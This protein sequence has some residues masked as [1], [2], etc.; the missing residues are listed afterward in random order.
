[1][2]EFKETLQTKDRHM[3]LPPPITTVPGAPITEIKK[4]VFLVYTKFKMKFINE[5]NQT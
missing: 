2:S 3:V 5:S 4:V 1:M